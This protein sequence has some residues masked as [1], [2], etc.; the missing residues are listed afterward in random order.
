M[1]LERTGLQLVTYV[2]TERCCAKEM[3][4]FAGQTCPEHRHTPFLSLPSF[5][6]SSNRLCFFAEVQ[7][8]KG[9]IKQKFHG[10]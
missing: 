2:N 9:S 3:V 8:N 6:A 4:L 7:Y 10:G 1:D 5:S